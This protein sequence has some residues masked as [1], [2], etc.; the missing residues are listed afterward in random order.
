MTKK[1]TDAAQINPTLRFL[2]RGTVFYRPNYNARFKPEF[3]NFQNQ[4][5]IKSFSILETVIN[6]KAKDIWI[7]WIFFLKN[8][9]TACPLKGR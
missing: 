2:H 1:L 5:F 9:E 8:E 4:I 3:S 7:I 6:A